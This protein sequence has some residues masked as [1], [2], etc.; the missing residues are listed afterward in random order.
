VGRDGP[1]HV[2]HRLWHSCLCY[3]TIRPSVLARS[4][5]LFPV[6]LTFPM[7][8]LIYVDQ[9][10]P[11]SALDCCCCNWNH[12]FLAPEQLHFDDVPNSSWSNRLC[13]YRLVHLLA[14]YEMLDTE[15]TSFLK[16]FRYDLLDNDSQTSSSPS[17]RFQ[18]TVSSSLSLPYSSTTRRV[19]KYRSLL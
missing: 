2:R 18:F 6:C 13:S 16:N 10:D 4:Q 5:P 15:V 8:R 3:A 19:S 1:V 9:I 12:S 14:A 11:W 17:Q 7:M